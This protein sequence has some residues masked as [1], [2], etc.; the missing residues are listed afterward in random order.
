VVAAG[1]DHACAG[2]SQ[3]LRQYLHQITGCESLIPG[4]LDEEAKAIAAEDH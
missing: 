1:G 2:Q 4:R 3:A